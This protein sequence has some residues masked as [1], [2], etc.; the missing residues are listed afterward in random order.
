MAILVIGGAGYIGSHMTECLI[1][2][3]Q[4][5]VVLDNLSTGHI[6]FIESLMRRVTHFECSELTFVEGDFGD[7]A[8]MSSILGAKYF[9]CHVQLCS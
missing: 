7:K 3:G 5:V 2:N 1:S 8:L 4:K 9:F 6:E